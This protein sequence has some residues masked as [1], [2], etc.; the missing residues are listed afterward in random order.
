MK[1]MSSSQKKTDKSARNRLQRPSYCHEYI[2][3][4]ISGYEELL[5]PI[6]EMRE[7]KSL[8]LF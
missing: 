4:G 3:Q 7:A 2:G 8:T 5:K 1:V 6:K